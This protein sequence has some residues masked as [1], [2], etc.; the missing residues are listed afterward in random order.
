MSVRI[1][2]LDSEEWHW[3]QHSEIWTITEDA[4]VRLIDEDIPPCHLE[5]HEVIDIND[6]EEFVLKE[7]LG[8]LDDFLTEGVTMN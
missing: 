3:V 7:G 2:V 1:V 8:Q 6:V 5:H 4:L